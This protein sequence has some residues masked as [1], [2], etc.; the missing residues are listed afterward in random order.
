VRRW[1]GVEM[2][3]FDLLSRLEVYEQIA[4]WLSPKS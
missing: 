1:V 4:R 2:G 3:H